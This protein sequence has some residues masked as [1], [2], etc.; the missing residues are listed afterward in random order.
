MN[1]PSQ[2]VANR[3]VCNAI[4]SWAGMGVSMVIGILLMPMIVHHLGN[5]LFGVWVLVGT[6]LGYF[7]FLDLGLSKAIMRFVSK[8]I[9]QQDHDQA[10]KWITAALF[11]FSILSLLGIFL[12]GV[13]WLAAGRLI[14]NPQDAKVI[15]TAF[16]IAGL[17]FSLTLPTTRCFSG[18]LEAHLR[19]DII[20]AVEIAIA[21]LRACAVVWIISIGGSLIALVLATA[22]LSVLQGMATVFAAFYIHGPI[23][24]RLS[25]LQ[26]QEWGTFL[27]YATASF[28]TEIADIVRFRSSPLI[29][30]PF[31][32]LA[33]VTPFAIAERLSSLVVSMSNK[34]LSNLTPAFSQLEGQGGVDENESLRRSYFFGMKISCYIGTFSVGMV[35]LLSRPFIQR[36]MGPQFA[37]TSLLLAI[38]MIGHFF[39][40]IQIPTIC[41]L[42]ATS[43][44]KFYAY[45]NTLQA[46]LSIGLC[47]LLVIPFGLV[48][49]ALGM[50]I[51]TFIVKLFIQ[52]IGA[53]RILKMSLWRYHGL[54][55]LPNTAIPML[56]IISVYFI[57][58]L[59][60]MPDYVCIFSIAVIACLLFIPYILAFGFT[61]KE[62]HMLLRAVWPA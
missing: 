15:S 30:A 55:T 36:W 13:I 57:S 53:V 48:G 7:G 31:L 2:K 18:I 29:I 61:M 37:N 16:L 34:A 52:P 9:G 23:R 39:A 46:M 24:L 62:R 20:S 22:L 8:A 42:F 47:L 25:V 45:T 43:K 19:K 14:S 27:G 54:H 26:R 44:Q 60:R 41:L 56:F 28:I 4:T 3:I 12:S 59:F 50:A 58:K 5:R 17:A 33:A 1:S 10:D 51:P 11:S 38:L 40:I 32:G 35:I 6:L 49:V 21:L